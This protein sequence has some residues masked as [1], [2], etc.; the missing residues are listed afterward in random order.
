MRVFE[1]ISDTIGG[2]PLIK[3]RKV[4]SDCKARILLKCEFFNPLSSVKDRIAKSMIDDAEAAGKLK[5]GMKIVEPTSGNT[6]IGLA[7]I[8]AERG[9]PITL[10]MPETMSIERRILLRMLGAEIV[11]T[12]GPKGMTGASLV[13]KRIVEADSNAFMP[14]QFSN[15]ANPRVHHKTTAEEIWNDTDGKIDIFISG[16]GTGG[17]ITGVGENLRAKKAGLRIVAVEPTESPVLSGGS[18]SPHKIQG[19]GAGF[20]PEVLNTKI[21]DEVVKVSS[22]DALEMARKVIAA[23]GIPLGI[24]SG[25][26]VKAAIEVG[27]R[28]ENAGKII[29]AIAASSTER[30]LSTVLAEKARAEVTSLPVQQI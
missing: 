16:V 29:V 5:P 4:P 22:D 14:S 9:Y 24:S 18:P 13:A 20:V 8:A 30:Y 15:P 21:Y 26:A 10:V 7:F 3:L 17:T 27:S 19:I 11:L 1:N 23:E 2:T 28:P 6:G 12:P 25:A